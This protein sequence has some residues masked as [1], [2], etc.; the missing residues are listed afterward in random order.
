MSD[1]AALVLCSTKSTF[2]EASILLEDL[3]WHFQHCQAHWRCYTKL[4]VLLVLQYKS[5]SFVCPTIQNCKIEWPA[6]QNWPFYWSCN[7]NLAALFAQLY[8]TA[9]LIGP[10]YKTCR[11]GHRPIMKNFLVLPYWVNIWVGVG[12]ICLGVRK[13]WATIY[14]IYPVAMT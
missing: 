1:V 13:S 5:D 8:K 11:P 7:I 2:L 12:D 10:L 6:I 14:P 9:R 3:I 4:T